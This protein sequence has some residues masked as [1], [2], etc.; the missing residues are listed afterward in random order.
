MRSIHDM[1]ATVALDKRPEFEKAITQLRNISQ[2]L[3]WPF[4]VEMLMKSTP[5]LKGH[6]KRQHKKR[7]KAIL[8]NYIGSTLKEAGME[9]HPN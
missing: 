7:C 9:V 8:L 1:R 2:C 6:N 4:V 3:G 5:P